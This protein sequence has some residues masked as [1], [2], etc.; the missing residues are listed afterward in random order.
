M[1]FLW[2]GTRCENMPVRMCTVL[3]CAQK[4]KHI[5]RRMLGDG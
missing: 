3:S 4:S 2:L 1:G 5:L